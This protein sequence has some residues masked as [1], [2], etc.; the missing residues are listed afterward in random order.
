VAGFRIGTRTAL[1]AQP[2]AVDLSAEIGAVFVRLE[3]SPVRS[4]KPVTS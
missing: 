2:G 1:L 4:A 3:G